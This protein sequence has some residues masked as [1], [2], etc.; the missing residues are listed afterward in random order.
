M[1]LKS[2]FKYQFN[3]FKISVLIFYLVIYL[4]LISFVILA[5]IFTG[6]DGNMSG[7]EISSMVFLFVA[8]LNSFK[9]SF[10]MFLQNGVSRKTQFVSF[11][12]N[13]FPVAALMAL[14]DSINGTVVTMLTGNTYRTVFI[15]FYSQR[16]HGTV[17]GASQFIDGFFWSLSAYLMFVLIGYFLTI[18]YYRLNKAL[19]LTV[20]I[21]VPVFF[22]IVLPI[23]DSNFTSGRI[24]KFIKDTMAFAWGYKN[25][26]NP[27]FSVVSCILVS[28]V[29]AALSWLLMRKAVAK[30]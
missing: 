18:L 1:N 10:K 23:I 5:K 2:A 4:I 26:F 13:T 24:F 8:G 25:G 27:Y 20:S 7:I 22:L 14:I 9:E 6:T 30:D 29:M 12:L 21:G 3:N 16:Y 15:Q 17:L 28:A 11:I 19:K